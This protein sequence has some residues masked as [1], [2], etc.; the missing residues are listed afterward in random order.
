MV[1]LTKRVKELK[2][3]NDKFPQKYVIQIIQKLLIIIENH[4]SIYG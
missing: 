3:K 1:L 4:I 2:L